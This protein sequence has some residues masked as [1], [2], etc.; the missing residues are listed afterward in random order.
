M[1]H[2]ECTNMGRKEPNEMCINL[3]LHRLRKKWLENGNGHFGKHYFLE[4][5]TNNTQNDEDGQEEDSHRT[6][7]YLSVCPNMFYVSCCC[8]SLLDFIIIYTFDRV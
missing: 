1:E 4:G 5:T 7:F 6:S 8:C 2:T 3:F